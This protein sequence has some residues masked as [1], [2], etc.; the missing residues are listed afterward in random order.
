MTYHEVLSLVTC[1]GR[2]A[3]GT[4]QPCLGSPALLSLVTQAG[5]WPAVDLPQPWL[6]PVLSGYRNMCKG[7]GCVSHRDTPA[8]TP[9]HQAHTWDIYMWDTGPP[10]EVT[11]LS[12]RHKTGMRQ[13]D[14]SM[15]RRLAPMRQSAY[16]YLSLVSRSQSFPTQNDTI[17]QSGAP[18]AGFGSVPT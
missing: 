14:R 7:T 15:A 8:Q 10:Y 18:A 13:P 4:W 9:I 11:P 17:S 2:R 3:Q 12:F 5:L 1:S 16:A 6:Y